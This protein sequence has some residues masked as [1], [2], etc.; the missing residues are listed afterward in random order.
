M[1]RFSA[2]FSSHENKLAL[3]GEAAQRKLIIDKSR[4]KRRFMSEKEKCKSLALRF[5][6]RFEL[7]LKNP[8]TP[9]KKKKQDEG[10]GLYVCNL[11]TLDGNVV[12][13]FLTNISS[14]RIYYLND[15]YYEFKMNI[16]NYVL[17]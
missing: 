15:I 1:L 17:L 11:Y 4:I 10:W 6:M 3:L 16:L 9:P 14:W 8:T 2:L 5:V 12:G 13:I 7:S